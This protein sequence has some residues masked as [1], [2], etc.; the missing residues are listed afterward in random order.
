MITIAILVLLLYGALCLLLYFRQDAY[1]YFPSRKI[2]MTPG[3]LQIPFEDVR[4]ETAD[5]E[6]I[7]GWYTPGK[8][9]DPDTATVLFCHGNAGNIGDRAITVQTLHDIGLNVFMFDYRG[10]GQSTG[11]PSE[12]GTYRDAEAAWQYVVTQKKT[13]PENIIL[14]GRS[15]GGAVASWLAI[16]HPP[17]LLVLESCFTSIVDMGKRRFPFLPV[18]W[19]VRYSYDTLARMPYLECPLFVAHSPDDQLIPYALGKE[20]FDAAQTP[21][22]F[23][24]LTGGHNAGGM[25]VDAGY[26]K[27]VLDFLASTPPR[28]SD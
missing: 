22:C 8:N 19:L 14:V 1:V 13:A 17:R 10:Y 12:E 15:L 3:L 28:Q 27:A 25:N 5:G 21:K 26:R 23:Y 16:Q 2:S 6:F 4:I 20:I 9:A 24:D 7:T 11:T 18:T